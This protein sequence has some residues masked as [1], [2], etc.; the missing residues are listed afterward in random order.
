MDNIKLKQ[1][2]KF[3]A[4]QAGWAYPDL[5]WLSEK[6][7]AK[8]IQKREE[9][10]K[11]I[12]DKVQYCFAHSKLYT[13]NLSPGCVICG[14]GYWSCLFINVLCTRHCFFCPQDRMA[15][16]EK[17]PSIRSQA[18]FKSPKDYVLFLKKFKFK[19]VAFSGGEPFLVFNKLLSY[20]KKIRKEIGNKIY[21]W[22]YTN[23][24]LVTEDRLK[25]LK[26]AGLNEIRFNISAREY[27]LK[28][29]ELATNI[30]ET[31]AVEIPAIPED[32]RV[33]KR[34]IIEMQKIGVRYLNLHQLCTDKFN[35]KNFIARDYAL[36]YNPPFNVSNSEITALE[37]IRFAL[38]K[39]SSLSLNYCSSEYKDM[40]QTKGIRRYLA[41]LFKSDFED[42]TT[43]NF[44]RRLSIQDL[45]KNINEIIKILKRSK[46]NNK[47]WLVNHMGTEIYIQSS[48]LKYINF[49]KYTLTVSYF[50]AKF[51]EATDLGQEVRKIHF[52]TSDKVSI[53]KKLVLRMGIKNPA[54]IESFICLFIKNM[55]ESTIF[56]NLYRDHKFTLSQWRTEVDLLLNFKLYEQVNMYSSEMY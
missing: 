12:S 4:D 42:L 19:G 13:G 47:F 9:L 20:I 16:K 53:V 8:I 43:K 28:P 3:V 11:S 35:Y 54:T 38:R 40:F 22:V 56:H 50:D 6:E 37:L 17:L 21:L 27:D 33:V 36:L 15:N 51:G 5:K 24:D 41:P 18:K 1:R 49:H 32:L 23:G 7:N 25:R 39:K 46:F 52:Y 31:V 30:F 26:Q 10:L 55:N 29:V 14:E 2:I 44:I 34:R 48:L 45:P